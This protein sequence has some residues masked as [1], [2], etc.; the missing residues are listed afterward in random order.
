MDSETERRIVA[1]EQR[2]ADAEDRLQRQDDI[3]A[4][5][6][7]QRAYGYYLDKNLYRAVADLFTQ[8]GEIEIAARGVYKGRERIYEFLCKLLGGG[9]DGPVRG[10]I[11]NHFQLQAIVT[12]GADG[13]TAQA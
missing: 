1:L 2:L 10:H 12:L 11:G 3:E 5:K 6:K 8:D 7:L 9:H 4:I 13:C